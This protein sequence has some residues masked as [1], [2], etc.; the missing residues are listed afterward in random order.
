VD[1]DAVKSR[2]A[3]LKLSQAKAAKSAGMSVQWW[4]DLE[5]GKHENPRV[6][7]LL[8]MAAVL[9]CKVDDLL[10]K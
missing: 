9:G 1:P 6:L 8:R 3:A 10:R 7:T 2:R 5:N 4:S